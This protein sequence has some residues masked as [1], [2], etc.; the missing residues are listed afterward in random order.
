MT[1]SLFFA[2]LFPS[3]TA[4]AAQSSQTYNARMGFEVELDDLQHTGKRQKIQESP[5]HWWTLDTD[6]PKGTNFFDVEY[7]TQPVNVRSD[8]PGTYAKQI[9]ANFRAIIQN[10]DHQGLTIKHQSNV[11]H[12]RPQITFQ[13]P[14]KLIPILLRIKLERYLEDQ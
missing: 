11:N 3:A 14:L 9:L 1:L 7:T 8:Y 12:M 10:P 4:A 2:F 13:L 6:S 5:D